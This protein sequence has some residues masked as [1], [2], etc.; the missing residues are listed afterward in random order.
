MALQ[1]LLS[2]K[3]LN[4]FFEVFPSFFHVYV[5]DITYTKIQSQLWLYN[6]YYYYNYH[7]FFIYYIS[8]LSLISNYNGM[9][10]VVL[11][12]A[13]RLKYILKA[14]PESCDWGQSCPATLLFPAVC[15]RGKLRTF[16][17][18]VF[19]FKIAVIFNHLINYAFEHI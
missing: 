4:L 10:L 12:T 2:K 18:A 3:V 15:S 13:H 19:Y 9:E 11:A 5:V 14:P 16:V 8:I 1:D 17:S 7:Y 6:N